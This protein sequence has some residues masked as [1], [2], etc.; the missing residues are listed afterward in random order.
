MKRT[1]LAV[2]ALFAVAAGL[3]ALAHA[4]PLAGF[5]ALA[6]GSLGGPHQLAETLV[7]TS[8]FWSAAGVTAGQVSTTS[9]LTNKWIS[10]WTQ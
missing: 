3:M 7:Q 9:S 8:A 6:R 10:N 2:A 4:N 1:A 5:Y